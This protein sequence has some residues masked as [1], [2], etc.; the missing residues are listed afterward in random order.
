MTHRNTDAENHETI[1]EIRKAIA[2][3]YE[4]RHPLAIAENHIQKVMLFAVDELCFFIS[5]F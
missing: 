1:A 2:E 4:E 3:N 5:D